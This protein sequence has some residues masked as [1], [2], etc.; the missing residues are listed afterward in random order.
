MENPLA[1]WARPS[2]D[3]LRVTWLG[4]STVLLEVDGVR[5]LTDPVFGERAS[6]LS[7]AG[8]RRFDRAGSHRR[9][10]PARRDCPLARS[11]T[12][13]LCRPSMTELARLGV[14]LVTPLG[15][16]GHLEAFGWDARNISELDWGEQFTLRGRSRSLTASRRST[17]PGAARRSQRTLWSSW[18][19]ADREAPHLLQRRHRALSRIWPTSARRMARSIWSCSRWAPFIPAGVTSIWGRKRGAGAR[20]PRGGRLF[21]VHWGTFNL[22]LHDWQ[23]PAETLFQLAERNGISLSCLGWG[24]PP[25]RHEPRR[26][27]RGGARRRANRA[28]TRSLPPEPCRGPRALC[29]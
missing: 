15:V 6:P 8:P 5:I 28:L 7:F 4:H 10:P 18:V 26:R 20:A 23:E 3:H 19:I 16:G 14:P 22:G 27:P 24:P 1:A 29:A 11:P 12:H 17:S 25:S 9:S 13:Y 2:V 21:P